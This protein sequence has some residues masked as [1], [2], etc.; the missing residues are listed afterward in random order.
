[1]QVSTKIGIHPRF[2]SGD[3]FTSKN[4]KGLVPGGVIFK[5]KTGLW[6]T[7]QNS[8]K[9]HHRWFNEGVWKLWKIDRKK[10]SRVPF[11]WSCTNVVYSLLPDCT[12][13]TFW[14]FSER[15]GV[16]KSR[17]FQK[18]LYE[19][20]PFSLT[21]QPW[22]PEFLTSANSDSKKNISFEYS[23]IVGSL[24][25]KGLYWSHLIN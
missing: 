10:C 8:T 14:E 11:Y 5:Y 21:L 1:M 23:E 20:V 12:T 4:S 6:C 16:L 19:S 9:L 24:L 15:K 22:I 2:F 7:A 17:K 18:N 13:D 3:N 25:E